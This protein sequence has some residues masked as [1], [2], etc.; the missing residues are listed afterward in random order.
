VKINAAVRIGVLAA[1]ATVAVAGTTAPAGATTSSSTHVVINHPVIV[2][3]STATVAGYVS[4]KLANHVVYLQ[5][6]YSSGWY[7]VAQTPL[8]STS[9]FSFTVK[10]GAL[11]TYTFRVYDPASSTGVAA[12]YSPIVTLTTKRPTPA[13]HLAIDRTS[14]TLGSHAIIHGSVSPNLRYHVV[15]LQTHY[16]S[17]WYSVAHT[18]LTSTSGYSFTVKPSG[19]ATYTFRVYNPATGNGSPASVSRTVSLAVTKAAAPVQQCTPGY[20][21][22]IPPGPDVDCAGGSGNGPRYVVGPVYVTGSDPYDLD[23]DGNGIGCES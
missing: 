4:P 23:S 20:S 5:T 13:V 7:A 18:E 19:I 17:G 6:H 14:I 3:G 15:Y 10:P 9:H 16:S 8:N 21:P 11:T 1:T 2:L 22:C 12:S